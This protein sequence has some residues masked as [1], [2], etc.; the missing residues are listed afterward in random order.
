[1]DTFYEIL[2]V[3]FLSVIM[4][5][6]SLEGSSPKGDQRVI[7]SEYCVK[8]TGDNKL[9]TTRN[10]LMHSVTNTLPSDLKVTVRMRN[11]VVSIECMVPISPCKRRAQ[12]LRLMR[13]SIPSRH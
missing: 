1:M 7:P 2:P 11:G 3:I 4:A 8:K 12:P 10:I 6:K 5:M 13:D 9:S